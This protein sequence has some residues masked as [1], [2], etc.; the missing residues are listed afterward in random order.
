MKPVVRLLVLLA[1]FAS[2]GIFAQSVGRTEIKDLPK[3]WRQLATYELKGLSVDSGTKQNIPMQGSTFVSEA[4]NMLLVIESTTGGHRT[5]LKWLTMKC[6]ASREN[7]FTNDYG[8]NQSPRDTRCLVVNAR[9]S[10]KKYLEQVSPQAASAVKEENLKF[11][12]GQ[13]VRTWSGLSGGTYLKVYLFKNSPFKT[14][15]GADASEQELVT[16]GESLQKAVY[17]STLSLGGELP[18]QLLN[19]IK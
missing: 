15:S 18:L 14:A 5:T 6:P 8:S 19:T 10:D 7:Y 16:F 1:A 11:E 3:G 2:Q 9:Y 13:L 12:K 17:D 4:G